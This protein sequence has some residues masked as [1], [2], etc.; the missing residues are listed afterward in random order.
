MIYILIFHLKKIPNEYLWDFIR[1]FFDGDG[2]ISYS[3]ITKQSTFALYGTSE[4]FLSKLG[5]I[6]EKEFDVIKRV[7]PVKN[8][9]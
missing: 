8:L 1:G 3:D 2:Q 6:F 9:K 7:E 5:D 4:Q